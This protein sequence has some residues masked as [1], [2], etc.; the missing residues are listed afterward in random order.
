MLI[1]ALRKNFG[2]AL[3]GLKTINHLIRRN[4]DVKRTM[5]LAPEKYRTVSHS[6]WVGP[7]G[8]FSRSATCVAKMKNRHTCSRTACV[9]VWAVQDSDARILLCQGKRRLGSSIRKRQLNACRNTHNNVVRLVDIGHGRD[10]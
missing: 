7:P 1:S 3:S 9:A 4:I 5:L 10:E 2:D 8:L 6:V